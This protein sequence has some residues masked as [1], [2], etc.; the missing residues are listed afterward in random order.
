MSANRFRVNNKTHDIIIKSWLKTQ[1]IPFNAGLVGPNE[2]CFISSPKFCFVFGNICSYW[3]FLYHYHRVFHLV[4]SQHSVERICRAA[5]QL[6]YRSCWE[7]A[8]RFVE[9]DKS[10]VVFVEYSVFSGSRV[11]MFE[12]FWSVC[13]VM[14]GWFHSLVTASGTFHFLPNT[15]FESINDQLHNILCLPIDPVSNWPIP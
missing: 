4:S 2:I 10:H 5:D 13:E 12:L 1:E 14:C 7:T 6:T 11:N 15:E 9:S 3:T 8:R